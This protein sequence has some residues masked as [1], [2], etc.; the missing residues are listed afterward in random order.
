MMQYEISVI[1]KGRANG[2]QDK[3]N[4]LARPE[5]ALPLK[6]SEDKKFMFMVYE[7]YQESLE[8]SGLF[9]TD[10][11]TLSALGQLDTPIWKRRSIKEG[12]DACFVDEAH[13]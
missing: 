10:D 1:I 3:Y 2:N 12:Y 13:L 9:D 7:K 11:I 5:I 4:Q 8:H 6:T